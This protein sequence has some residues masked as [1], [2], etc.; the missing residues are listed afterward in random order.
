MNKT[1]GAKNEPEG[2]QGESNIS[3]L[4]KHVEGTYLT[5][6]EL[7][8]RLPQ[9]VDWLI[10]IFGEGSLEKM[11]FFLKSEIYNS[12]I[13]YFWTFGSEYSIIVRTPET[14]KDSGYT[15]CIMQKRKRKSSVEKPWMRGLDFI[16]GHYSE[17]T[18]REIAQKILSYEI[19]HLE[20]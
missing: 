7:K 20:L 8:E 9:F 4:E 6:D 3:W 17:E 19:Q 10:K 12:Y 5:T 1:E 18:I 16:D 11:M 13:I 14:D 15:G 2:V